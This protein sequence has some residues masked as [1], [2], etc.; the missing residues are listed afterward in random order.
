MGRR[1]KQSALGDVMD[2]V[3]L[4]P[5][6]AGLALALVSY[7]ILHALSTPSKAT[8]QAGQMGDFVA[9][10]M[11]SAFAFAG[12]FL[13]PFV[14]VL[15]A[16]LSAIH[17]HKRKGLVTT[18]TES[19]SAEALN[20]MSWQEFEMLVGEAFRVQGYQVTENGGGGA[21][22]GVDLVLRKGSETWLVQCK[23]WKT[24]KVGV[25]VVRELYGVMAARG[26]VGGFVV[27]SGTFSND[28]HQFASGRN[29]TL[30][31]KAQL[32]GLLQQGRSS[33]AAKTLIPRVALSTAKME[34][35]M[36][37]AIP[38]CPNCSSAMVLRT[39]KK[40]ANP[41]AQFWGCAKFPACWGKRQVV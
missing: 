14:C 12:Q 7:L 2:L 5:W 23:Q 39:A 27:T 37:P 41:G 28:A 21:D 19:S 3:A 9:R 35:S 6:W 24:F 34:P 4:L 26:A 10:S 33:R 16:G 1:R 13:V 25:G 29:V 31:D 22:G 20:G 18:V 17:R 36:V 8:L 30:I 32:F 15:G 38:A 40:G 11:I